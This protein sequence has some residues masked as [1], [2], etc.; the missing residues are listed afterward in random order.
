MPW[1]C[2]VSVLE[3]AVPPTLVGFR[4][5]RSRRHKRRHTKYRVQDFRLRVYVW[6]I[7]AQGLLFRAWG[8]GTQAPNSKY[9]ESSNQE[10]LAMLRESLC[11]S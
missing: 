3:K 2:S 11:S 8:L 4:S 9:R 6:C 10:Q 5:V 1:T 7:G